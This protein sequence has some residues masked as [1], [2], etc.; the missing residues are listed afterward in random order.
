MRLAC[1]DLP[2]LAIQTACAWFPTIDHDYA[3]LRPVTVRLHPPEI[4]EEAHI[5][6]IGEHDSGGGCHHV[7]K[8]AASTAFSTPSHIRSRCV[9]A[10]GLMAD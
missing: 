9:G 4:K 2:P 10:V 6:V 5:Y 8:I 7:S 1:L 3:R